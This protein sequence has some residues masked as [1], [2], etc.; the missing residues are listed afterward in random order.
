MKNRCPKCR[1]VELIPVRTEAAVVDECPKCKGVWFD[2]QGDELQRILALG[3]DRLPDAL[4]DSWDANPDAGALTTAVVEDGDDRACPK[5]GAIMNRY[6]YAAEPGRTFLVD[7][8]RHGVWLD[9]GELRKAWE[10]L[11]GFT[12]TRKELERKGAVDAALARAEGG[13]EGPRSIFQDKSWGI[14]S[15]ILNTKMDSWSR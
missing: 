13:D 12:K 3:R 15:S 10:S 7:G 8:C 1:E 2:A 5:C 9:A 4:K 14:I 6:W 11:A